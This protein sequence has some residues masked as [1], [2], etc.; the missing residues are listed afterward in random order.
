MEYHFL[1]FAN[2]NTDWVPV[3]FYDGMDFGTWSASA[4]AD[5]RGSPPF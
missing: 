5:F 4:P 3:R 2:H 1:A